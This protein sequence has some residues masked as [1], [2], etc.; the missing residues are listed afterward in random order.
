MMYLQVAFFAECLRLLSLILV[1]G[2]FCKHC[3]FG[4]HPV[5]VVDLLGWVFTTA[6]AGSFTAGKG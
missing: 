2:D 5:F 3:P 1:G 4:L 6:F